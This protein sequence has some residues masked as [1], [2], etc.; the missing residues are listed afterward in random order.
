[1]PPMNWSIVAWFGGTLGP[2][3][4]WGFPVFLVAWVLLFLLVTWIL[5]TGNLAGNLSVSGI[6][7][8]RGVRV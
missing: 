7:L 6:L 5:P 3:R 1:M 4:L 2:V 8:G